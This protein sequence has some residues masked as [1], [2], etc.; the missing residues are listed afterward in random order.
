MSYFAIIVAYCSGYIIE[1]HN[2]SDVLDVLISSTLF[3]LEG[4]DP[5]CQVR[6][7]SLPDILF[8][9]TMSLWCP[10]CGVLQYFPGWSHI[11]CVQH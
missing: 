1:L 9:H 4:V 10:F 8:R 2:D 7:C 11:P 3:L 5:T 6:F